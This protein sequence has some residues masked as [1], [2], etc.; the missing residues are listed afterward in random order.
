MTNNEIEWH[1][2]PPHGPHCGGAWERLV[3]SAKRA[4]QVKMGI[5]ITT[6]QVLRTHVAEVMSLLNCRPLTHLSL[7]PTDPDPL[8]PNH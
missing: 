4:L 5:Q 1:F 8:T 3:Q 2:S 6:D 7:E